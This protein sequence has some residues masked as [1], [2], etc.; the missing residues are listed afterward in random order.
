MISEPIGTDH[1]LCHLVV[2]SDFGADSGLSPGS[3]LIARQIEKRAPVARCRSLDHKG[4]RAQRRLRHDVGN[5]SLQFIVVPGRFEERGAERNQVLGRVGVQKPEHFKCARNVMDHR[6]AAIER[7]P[8]ERHTQD[9][10]QHIVLVL[11]RVEEQ[12]S[13][14][15][16]RQLDGVP[17]IGAGATQLRALRLCANKIARAI[18]APFKRRGKGLAR[19]KRADRGNGDEL[20]CGHCR[21][22]FQTDGPEGALAPNPVPKVGSTVPRLPR[23]VRQIPSWDHLLMLLASVIVGISVIPVVGFVV[24]IGLDPSWGLGLHTAHAQNLAFGRDVMWT[25]GPLGFLVSPTMAYRVTGLAAYWIRLPAFVG[26]AWLVLR[27]LRSIVPAGRSHFRRVVAAA[28]CVAAAFPI[29]WLLVGGLG[30]GGNLIVAVYVIAAAFAVRA[31]LTDMVVPQRA[32]STAA[33]ASGLALLVRFDTGLVGFLLMLLVAFDRKVGWRRIARLFAMFAST[34]LVTWILLGQPISTLLP[35]VH[36]SIELGRGYGGGMAWSA[37]SSWTTRASAGVVVATLLAVG[38][39]RSLRRPSV[40]GVLG[41]LG[42]A[43]TTFQQSFGRYDSGHVLRLVVLCA[44]IVLLF[45]NR[46]NRWVSVLCMTFL[47]V[48]GMS[49]N[50]AGQPF[51][52]FGWPRG[53]VPFAHPT[54]G[55]RY[56]WR[57]FEFTVSVT[58]YAGRVRRE[59]DRLGPLQGIPEN[60]R[61]VARGK[62]VHIDPLE[63]SAIWVHGWAWRPLPVFQTYQ[64]NTPMLDR[65]NVRVLLNKKRAPQVILSQNTA[66][67]GRIPRWTPPESMLAMVC[68]YSPNA[69]GGGWTAWTRRATSACGRPTALP[70]FAP[71]DRPETLVVARFQRNI[72][73]LRTL[74]DTPLLFGIN[75]GPAVSRVTAALAGGPHI[76]HVPTCLREAV[77]SGAGFDTT[78]LI[79]TAL[80]ESVTSVEYGSIPFS[81]PT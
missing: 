37:H 46:R 44:A 61:A 74:R 21:P 18:G 7:R 9:P 66:I 48:T 69:S 19:T 57:T 45:A 28:V 32:L 42:L 70:A 29:T 3:A 39:S 24:G 15:R 31:V 75:G 56:A 52:R 63:T 51:P 22:F 6:S 38:L 40:F 8:L 49:L 12:L 79:P 68:W 2:H 80:P 47:V 60:V 36:G 77:G 72:S 50:D 20:W 25:F 1:R 55:F 27:R 76:V 10:D 64:A 17:L 73:A 54:T 71:G 14:E 58:R 30:G 4:T 11:A 59:H 34:V 81:C 65:L 26:V 67:D 43:L 53:E 16:I 41:L 33:V 35:Y 13:A 5:R 78:D 23:I 62:T